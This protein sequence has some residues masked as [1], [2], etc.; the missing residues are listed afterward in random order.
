MNLYDR[1]RNDNARI[2]GSGF[3]LPVVFTDPAGVA[4]PADAFFK[5]TEFTVDMSGQPSSARHLS[6]SVNLENASGVVQFTHAHRPKNGWRVSFS[7]NGIDFKGEVI[8]AMFDRT[9]GMIT[10][11]AQVVKA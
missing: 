1:A 10:M 3:T 4:C 6:I 8:L 2:L 9:L 11:N 7:Y 5:D